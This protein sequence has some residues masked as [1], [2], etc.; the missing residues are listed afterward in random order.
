MN[1]R[2][3]MHKIDT[4]LKLRKLRLEIEQGQDGALS[5]EQAA[6]LTDICQALGI[7]QDSETYYVVG[8]G[9]ASFVAAPVPYRPADQLAGPTAFAVAFA[10]KA[11]EA[12]EYTVA[13]AG[14]RVTLEKA[15]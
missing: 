12:G 5:E 4:M 13:V 1:Q 8:E 14:N 15:G 7:V 10:R 6:L 3:R 2:E 9:F 11:E